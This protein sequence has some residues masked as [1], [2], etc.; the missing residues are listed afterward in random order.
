M[1][2]VLSDK[3]IPGGRRG[4]GARAARRRQGVGRDRGIIVLYPRKQEGAAFPRRRIGLVSGWQGAQ[5]APETRASEDRT[6]DFRST[7]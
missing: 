1:N 6:W 4:H 3:S 5:Q 7:S 2:R